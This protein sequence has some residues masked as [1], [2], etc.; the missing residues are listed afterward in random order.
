MRVRRIRTLTTIIKFID[1]LFDGKI[2]ICW[3]VSSSLF[4][5][6]TDDFLKVKSYKVQFSYLMIRAIL[7]KVNTYGVLYPKL[8]VVSL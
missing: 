2:G 1:V 8:R 3:K 4:L 6:C 7:F 5:D